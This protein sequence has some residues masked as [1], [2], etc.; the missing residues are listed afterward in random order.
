M[1]F[2]IKSKENQYICHHFFFFP[3]IAEEELP[4]FTLRI[5]QTSKI[6]TC[7]HQGES[8]TK[9]FCDVNISLDETEVEHHRNNL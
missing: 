8:E 5:V 2:G 7:L 9:N 1:K 3:S 6:V 4:W